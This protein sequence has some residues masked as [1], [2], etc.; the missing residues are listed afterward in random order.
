MLKESGCADAEREEIPKIDRL[1]RGES[2]NRAPF[3]LHPIRIEENDRALLCPIALIAPGLEDGVCIA[4]LEVAAR[5]QCAMI[6]FDGC[7]QFADTTPRFV[8]EKILVE[9]ILQPQRNPRTSVAISFRV[10]ILINVLKEQNLI[11]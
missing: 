6:P 9:R 5:E 7:L 8:D 4:V 10:R 2:F 3:D 11:S 1:R